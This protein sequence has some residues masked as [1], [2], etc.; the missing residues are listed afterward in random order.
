MTKTLLFLLAILPSVLFGQATKKVTEEHKH[1]YS[2]EVYYVLKS[3]K[4][5]RHGKYQKLYSNDVLK[6][7]GFYK[8]GLK[9][10]IWINYRWDGQGIE[11]QGYYAIDKKVGVWDF[12][13]FKKELEQK[14][15]FTKNE[16]V[17]FLPDDE[18]MKEGYNVI[19]GSDTI[20]TQLDQPPLYISGSMQM[21]EIIVE[22]IRYPRLALEK[23]TSGKVYITFTIDSTGKTSGHRITEG[24]G[25]GCDEE[26][27]RVARLIPDSWVPGLLN[28]HSVNVEY[29]LPIQYTLAK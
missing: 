25:S 28:G 11:S 2:K 21:I 24:I 29:V 4:K 9:D 27:L 20:R 15:D 23:G 22:N 17:Y 8:N 5:I 10:S 14:Y 26:A 7:E 13:N 1:P 12:Y 18:K 19:N 3:D 6:L 16:V